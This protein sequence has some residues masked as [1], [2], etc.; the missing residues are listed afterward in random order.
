MADLKQRARRC[1]ALEG[2][3]TRNA[4]RGSLK[5]ATVSAS[6]SNDAF[7]TG[8][9][10]SDSVNECHRSGSGADDDPTSGERLGLQLVR[11]TANNGKA[12]ES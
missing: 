9:Q 11:Q 12:P 10:D 7:W 2:V 3:R 1:R 4:N 6:A 8:G 5:P